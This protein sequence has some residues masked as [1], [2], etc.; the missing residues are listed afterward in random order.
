MTAW[1]CGSEQAILSLDLLNILVSKMGQ[2]HVVPRLAMKSHAEEAV[3]AL[4]GLRWDG[5]KL[6]IAAVFSSPQSA[7]IRA[8]DQ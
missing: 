8:G 1:L 5:S 6:H 7:A 3:G 4:Q 2:C